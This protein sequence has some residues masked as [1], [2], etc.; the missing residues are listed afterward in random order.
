[1]N[2]RKG[3]PNS[4][5]SVWGENKPRQPASPHFPHKYRNENPTCTLPESGSL[6]SA[7]LGK[8]LLSVTT[9]FT[10]SRTLS[11]GKHSARN[12][13]QVPNIRRTATL[14][15]RAVSRRLK[16]MVVIF[17]ESQVLALGKEASVPFFCGILLHYVDLHVPFYHNYKSVFYNY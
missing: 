12:L 1:M 10:K 9:M 3:R 16:L 13:C 14:G 4:H 17:A 5:M 11:T 7:A 8:V 15:K 6:P 2:K